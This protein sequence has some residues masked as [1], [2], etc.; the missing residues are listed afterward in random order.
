MKVT[1]GTA[2]AVLRVIQLKGTYKVDEIESLPIV[3]PLDSYIKV[4]GCRH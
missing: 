1:L 3:L 2:K 4:F